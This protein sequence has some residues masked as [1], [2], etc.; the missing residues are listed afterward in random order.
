MSEAAAKSPHPCIVARSL[1]TTNGW[2]CGAGCYYRHQLRGR[3]LDRF[4]ND[5]AHFGRRAHQLKGAARGEM[6]MTGILQRHGMRTRDRNG[7]AGFTLVEILV[8]ITIIG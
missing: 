7:E 1:S 3:R 2:H 5:R 6:P 8:V 4:G